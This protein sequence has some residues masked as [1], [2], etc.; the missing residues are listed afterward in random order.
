MGMK[1]KRL[2][3]TNLMVSENS[4]GGL[5]LQ[6]LDEKDGARLLQ[7]AYDNGINFFDTARAYTCSESHIGKGLHDVRE[8]IYI[9]TKSMSNTRSG[10]L[11]DLETSLENLQTNYV[12]LLQLHCISDMPDLTDPESPYQALLEARVAGKTR[13][14]GAT[15]HRLPVAVEAAKSGLFDTVQ[16]PLSYLS[17]PEELQ[18]AK[19]CQENDVGLIAMKAMGGGLISSSKAAFAFFTQYD[20]IVPIWGMQKESELDEFLHYAE[21]GLTFTQDMQAMIDK[22]KKE[23]GD[24]FCRGCGYCKATCP[25]K[26]E[27]QNVA[28]MNLIIQR[29]PW[30]EFTTPYWIE[31]MRKIENCIHCGVCKSHCPY[32][33]DTPALLQKS[34]EE[35]MAFCREKGIL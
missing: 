21:A 33:L 31:E 10:V 25:A 11:A 20:N 26:I 13:F 34:Y 29:G 5:P 4:F 14:I 35:Y 27:I 7:R 3:R 32:Q 24:N 16:Y 12:D 15:S 28:R 6:R 8:K 18:L 9:A 30:Q 2:G 22:D 23:L 19:V 1:M 17:T